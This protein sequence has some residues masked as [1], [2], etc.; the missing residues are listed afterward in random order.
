[1]ER[2]GRPARA[3][4]PHR[5]LII[6]NSSVF[7]A[8]PGSV[9]SE[10]PDRFRNH[11][12][13]TRKRWRNRQA[14]KSDACRPKQLGV[15]DDT[16]GRLR[17]IAAAAMIGKQEPE[18]RTKPTANQVRQTFGVEK[19]QTRKKS[20]RIT[21][22]CGL[23]SPLEIDTSRGYPRSMAALDATL[24]R[25]EVGLAGP[26]A[27]PVR[28]KSN[29][30]SGTLPIV[31]HRPWLRKESRARLPSNNIFGRSCGC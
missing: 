5:L 17:A 22:G 19:R 14:F 2:Q 30:R 12:R 8:G 27:V 24:F 13:A 9:R 25:K 4:E 21:I 18:N 1:M 16:D 28:H 10:R 20:Q 31:G 11:H 3:G 26:Q 29:E 6:N 7:I 23:R 15:T